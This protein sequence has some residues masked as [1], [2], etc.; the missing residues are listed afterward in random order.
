[1]RTVIKAAHPSLLTLTGV[2]RLAAWGREMSR[3]I[4]CQWLN[5]HFSNILLTNSSDGWLSVLRNSTQHS[6]SPINRQAL[7]VH[8]YRHRISG[9]ISFMFV[10]KIGY[11]E[12]L[13]LEMKTIFYF[14]TRPETQVN[15]SGQPSL[16]AAASLTL[17]GFQGRVW[18]WADSRAH[19]NLEDTTPIKIIS[20]PVSRPHRQGSRSDHWATNGNASLLAGDQ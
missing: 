8:C 12:C 9:N 11:R 3:L 13:N 5:Q 10:L 4:Q 2:G 19:A 14:L 16:A 7:A 15:L 20:F 1:M 17:C 6:K 18:T